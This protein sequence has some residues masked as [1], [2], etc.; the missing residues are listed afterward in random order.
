MNLCTGQPGRGIR[1]QCFDYEVL[2]VEG[3]CKNKNNNIAIPLQV[4]FSIILPSNDDRQINNRAAKEN[5]GVV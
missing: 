5:E 3:I 2:K 4:S 1:H